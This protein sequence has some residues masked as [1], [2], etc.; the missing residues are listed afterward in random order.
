VKLK[1]PVYDDEDRQILSES[2][3][4][5]L[6]GEEVKQASSMY[7]LKNSLV[8]RVYPQLDQS[9]QYEG[10]LVVPNGFL[11]ISGTVE[12]RDL[13]IKSAISSAIDLMA[14]NY[15]LQVNPDDQRQVRIAISEVPNYDDY[16]YL[17]NDLNS[18]LMVKRVVPESLKGNDVQ[19]LLD[20]VGSVELLQLT[21]VNMPQLEEVIEIAPIEPVVSETQVT[22]TS[23]EGLSTDGAPTEG[24]SA[25]EESNASTVEEEIQVLSY[26]YRIKQAE[27]NQKGYVKAK[28]QPEL[29]IEE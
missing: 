14:D 16:H 29:L 20:I 4:W 9:W 1:F 18:F 21:L 10:L 17:Q 24:Q 13:A 19:L 15:S 7:Q 25:E 27:Q 28:D 22:E 11:P 12:S 8:V 5:G 26:K 23:V 6:F 3:L 2:A